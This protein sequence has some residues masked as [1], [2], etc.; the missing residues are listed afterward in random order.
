MSLTHIFFDLDGTLV[1]SS[2]GIHNGFVQTF[3][4]L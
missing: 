4:R 2:E 1:D 3:E